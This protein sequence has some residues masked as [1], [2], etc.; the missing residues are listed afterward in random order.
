MVARTAR[1][2]GPT[3]TPPSTPTSSPTATVTATS[4]SPPTATPPPLTPILSPTPFPWASPCCLVSGSKQVIY[5]IDHAVYDDVDA[6]LELGEWGAIGMLQQALEKHHPQWARHTRM[7]AY[8]HRYN[9]AEYVWN[10]S[11]AQRIG[12][13]PHVLLMTA[14][15]ARTG[16]SP[17]TRT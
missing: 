1:R 10:I 15:M 4:T 16:E 3:P 2:A 12:V 5:P 8:G 6:G 7:D 13:N 9:V 17:K 14:G 11:N